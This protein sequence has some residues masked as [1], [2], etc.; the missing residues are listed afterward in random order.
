MTPPDDTEAVH[1]RRLEAGAA[2]FESGDTARAQT[3]FTQAAED[4]RPGPER[5]AAL[6]RLARVH[7]Y[8]GD[9][10]IAVELFRKSLDEAGTKPSVR[11]DAAE[12]LANSLF[13]LREDL[14]E[15]LDHAHFAAQVARD[16][17][18]RGALAV[19]LGTQGTIETVLGHRDAAATLQSAL[20]LEHHARDVTLVRQPSF[21]LAFVRVWTDEL[22]RLKTNERP[23]HSRTTARI[24]FPLAHRHRIASFRDMWRLRLYGLPAWSGQIICSRERSDDVLPTQPRAALD[25]GGRSN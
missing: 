21:Q 18:D 5:A 20:A 3:L 4:A 9:Q 1:R 19:A 16:E 12:G 6:S 25:L 10:R 14:P 24:R 17:A 7:H 22:E 11:A 2:H 23:T 13:F 15:A 8:A